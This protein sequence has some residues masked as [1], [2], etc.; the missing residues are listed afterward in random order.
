M[1][2]YLCIQIAINKMQLF[3]LAIGYAWP[4]HN[5]IM[6]QSVHNADISKP[7]TQTYMWSAVVRPVG[8]IA[9]FS[10]TKLGGRLW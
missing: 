7:L 2:Q 4:Y 5:P 8:R 1:V 9:K 10:K 3:S 6:G